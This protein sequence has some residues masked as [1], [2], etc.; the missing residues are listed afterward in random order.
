M[1]TTMLSHWVG[2]G[3]LSWM[4]PLINFHPWCRGW[5]WFQSLIP[6]PSL[7]NLAWIETALLSLTSLGELSFPFNVTL[8]YQYPESIQKQIFSRIRTQIGRWSAQHHHAGLERLIKEPTPPFP[9]TEVT[10]PP[11][12]RDLCGIGSGKIKRSRG[13]ENLFWCCVS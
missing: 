12:L 9:P 4:Y 10:S 3:S 6:S 1:L 5:S 2:Q 13:T 11:D 8:S 7:D